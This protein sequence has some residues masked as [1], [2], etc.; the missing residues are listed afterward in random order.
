[1]SKSVYVGSY[2]GLRYVVV[3]ILPLRA[4]EIINLGVQKVPEK[5]F[6]ESACLAGK[7]LIQHVRVFCTP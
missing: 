5:K 7:S 2:L 3:Q 4:L 1:M 6:S